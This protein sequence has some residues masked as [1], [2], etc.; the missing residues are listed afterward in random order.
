MTSEH[1]TA[2]ILECRPG[3]Y[4]Q[5]AAERVGLRRRH[6]RSRVDKVTQDTRR[7]HPCPLTSPLQGRAP[8][9]GLNHYREYT[10]YRVKPLQ[11]EALT[12]PLQ[13]I[14]PLQA[15]NMLEY[16]LQDKYDPL[17]GLLLLHTLWPNVVSELNDRDELRR[18]VSPRETLPKSSKRSR[19]SPSSPLCRNPGEWKSV[20]R[21]GSDGL[22]QHER[23]RQRERWT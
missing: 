13:G 3:K 20:G 18:P 14:H 9:Q 10:P 19:S 17:R 15:L 22:R 5:I 11:G 21:S 1:T 7:L 12:S 16:L 6:D 4:A 23:E 8:L 2:Q